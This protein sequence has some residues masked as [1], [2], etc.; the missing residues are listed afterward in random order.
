MEHP[1]SDKIGH[2]PATCD[3]VQHGLYFR[4]PIEGMPCAQLRDIRIKKR[5]LGAAELLVIRR[6]VLH[7]VAERMGWWLNPYAPGRFFGGRNDRYLLREN[8]SP[9]ER[10]AFIQNDLDVSLLLGVA[11]WRQ[12]LGLEL[13][14]SGT[15]FVRFPQLLDPT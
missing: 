11:D 6:A 12:R 13:R 14:G 10:P 2:D 9:P 4:V 7:L 8:R 15:Q 1:N 5:L 3:V